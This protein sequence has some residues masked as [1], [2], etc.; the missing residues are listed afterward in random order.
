MDRLAKPI[1]KAWETYCKDISYKHQ[2]KIGH[3]LSYRNYKL[4]SLQQSSKCN[5]LLI[6][7]Y[8]LNINYELLKY[9][10][11]LLEKLEPKNS[12]PKFQLV[13]AIGPFCKDS[14]KIINLR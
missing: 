8:Q 12:V 11:F 3:C 14:S 13:F 1:T 2:L 4:Q 9:G 7:F 10:I 5:D 6:S